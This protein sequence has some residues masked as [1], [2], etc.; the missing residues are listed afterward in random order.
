MKL[1]RVTIEYTGRKVYDLEF[2]N[3]DEAVDLAKN[4]FDD[5][6]IYENITCI[7]AKE[8]DDTPKQQSND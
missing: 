8:F 5:E 7:D 6:T 2:D 1:W 3:K 4:C